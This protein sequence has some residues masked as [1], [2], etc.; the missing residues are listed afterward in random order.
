LEPPGLPIEG[1]NIRCLWPLI[2]QRALSI[3]EVPEAAE[4]SEANAADAR[5]SRKSVARF[6]RIPAHMIPA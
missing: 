1:P 5:R 3:A 6:P 4:V 2:K